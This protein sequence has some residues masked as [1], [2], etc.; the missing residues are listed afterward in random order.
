MREFAV[1]LLGGKQKYVVNCADGILAQ[2]RGTTRMF[3]NQPSA[4]V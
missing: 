2:S 1:D 3:F 4:V